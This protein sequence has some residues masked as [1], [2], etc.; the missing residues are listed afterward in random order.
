MSI[1]AILLVVLIVVI[2]AMA[3]RSG[4]VNYKDPLTVLLWVVVICIA[5][6]LIWGVLGYSTVRVR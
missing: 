1:L 5:V 4:S 6:Y 2:I 3:I